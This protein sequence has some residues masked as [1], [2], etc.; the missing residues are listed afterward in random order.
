MSAIRIDHFSDILCI[1]AY[2]SDIRVRELENNFPK[3]VEFDFHFFPIFGNV[4]GKMESVWGDRGGI[5]AYAKHVQETAAQF[6]HIKLHPDAW[7]KVQPYSSLPSHLYLAAV[8][9]LERDTVIAG[10]S[11]RELALRMRREFFEQARDISNAHV[12]DEIVTDTQLPLAD[13]KEAIDSGK[14]YAHF[15]E[16]IQFARD[17]N[18]RSSPTLIFN[19]DR[20]RLSGNVGYRIIEANIK[21][22]IERPVIQHSWC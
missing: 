12:L 20:Q 1:W 13:I 15:A 4:P 18:I 2:I 14:A 3:Q 9:Q 6:D 11:Y 5:G 17:K 16:D 21:E 19:D 10:Y 22:L 7:S 8:K